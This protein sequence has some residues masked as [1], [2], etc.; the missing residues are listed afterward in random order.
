VARA[1]EQFR[2]K[3][4]DEPSNGLRAVDVLGRLARRGQPTTLAE[5]VAESLKDWKR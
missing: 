1:L 4:L 2:G 5:D 3:R